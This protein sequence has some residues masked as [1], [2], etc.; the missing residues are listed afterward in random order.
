MRAVIISSVTELDMASHGHL[1]Q[2]Y[3]RASFAAK[4][5]DPLVVV[6]ISDVLLQEMPREELLVATLARKL[7]IQVVSL[8]F[9]VPSQVLRVLEHLVAH[10]AVTFRV[11]V[12]VVTADSCRFVEDN[13]AQRAIE[14][15]WPN[16]RMLLLKVNEKCRRPAA[17]FLAPRAVY[18]DQGSGF[19]SIQLV[20]LQLVPSQARPEQENGVTDLAG[21]VLSPTAVMGLQKVTL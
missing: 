7:T 12:V 15:R 6:N 9:H 4:V 14:R 11:K 1:A 17:T 8:A 19:D 2:E 18:F 16:F 3:F 5:V 20:T 21:K 13:F 10:L